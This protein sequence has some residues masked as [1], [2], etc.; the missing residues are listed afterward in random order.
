M[1][2]VHK[3]KLFF[4]LLGIPEDHEIRQ[5]IQYRIFKTKKAHLTCRVKKLEGDVEYFLEEANIKQVIHSLH[6]SVKAQKALL[7][8]S[9]EPT[10]EVTRGIGNSLAK[11]GFMLFSSDNAMLAKQ[12]YIKA[13]KRF[14]QIG[15]TARCQE[16]NLELEK[17]QEVLRV[18]I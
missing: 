13:N 14:E 18:E 5:K 17:V 3:S 12:A 15:D 7:K 16:I 6:E 1:V 2:F 10:N 9:V 4:T 11:L 8:M